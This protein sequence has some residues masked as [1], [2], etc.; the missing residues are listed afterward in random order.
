MKRK[1]LIQI[2]PYN[3]ITKEIDDGDLENDSGRRDGGERV[4]DP[5]PVRDQH[6][7]GRP[8]TSAPRKRGKR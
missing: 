3:S 1:V 6:E 2:D 5:E 8:A 4:P 7:L